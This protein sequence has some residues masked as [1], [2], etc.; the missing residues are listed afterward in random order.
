VSKYRRRRGTKNVKKSI[1]NN[2]GEP[3]RILRQFAVEKKKTVTALCLIALMVFMWL[4]V[5]VGKTPRSAEGALAT[6]TAGLNVAVPDSQLKISLIEL[7]KVNGRN[8]ILTRDFFVVNDWV[9]FI[10]DGEGL[11]GDGEVGDLKE[12]A[13]ELARRLV[14]KLR[15]E[16]IGLGEN[17]QA[18]INDKLLSV[19]DKF[20]VG[21]GVNACEC[22]VVGIQENSVSV[23]CREVEIQL[24]LGQG[25]ERSN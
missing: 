3:N 13:E 7:P 22:E 2:G 9:D 25:N 11:I 21:D 20:L 6:Q 8:D 24:K 19:G 18:F 5:L 12:G 10:R 17:P 16:A 4:K 1:E 23:R 14:R 15:L